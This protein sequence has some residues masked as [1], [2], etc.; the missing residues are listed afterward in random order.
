MRRR[1]P[2]DP[3]LEVRAYLDFLARRRRQTQMENARLAALERE[4]A[5]LRRSR[6][7]AR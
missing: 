1:L 7:E 5:A 4:M 3:R 2:T 6:E